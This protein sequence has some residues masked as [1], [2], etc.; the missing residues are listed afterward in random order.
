[1]R[2]TFIF[3]LLIPVVFLVSDFSRASYIGVPL[4]DS[5][6]LPELQL[7]SGNLLKEAIILPE[8]K[9]DKEEAAKIILRIDQLPTSVLSE[10]QKNHIK[11]ILFT[12]KLTDQPYAD[13]LEGQVPR[14]YPDSILWDDLPGAGGTHHVLV[15]IGYSEKG[16][17]HGSVNLEYHELAHSLHRLVFYDDTT[18]QQITQTWK[19]EAD[20]LFPSND[21][22]LHYKEEFFAE[23]FAYY[24]YS[25]ETRQQLAKKAPKMY[26]FLESL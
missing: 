10:I 20:S 16:R 21:Y 9:F 19:Q 11:I 4:G 22:F 24:F 8:G 25:K 5:E 7:K 26:T 13:H 15:K 23:C 14:G 18:N 12:G 3:L 2:K 17:G 1:M 6:L